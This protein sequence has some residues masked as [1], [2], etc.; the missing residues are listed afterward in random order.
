MFD[1]VTTTFESGMVIN[2]KLLSKP[3]ED[4]LNQQSCSLDYTFQAMM[5]DI[6]GD[7]INEGIIIVYMD[8]IFNFAPDNVTLTNNTRRV[9]ARLQENN[10]FLKPAKF[11]FYKTRVE[12]QGMIIEEGRI[13]MDPGKLKGIRDWPSPTMVKQTRGFLRF[14]NFY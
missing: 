9:L 11:E 12:Y 4:F 3:I 13:S 8:D 1:V 5:D 6:F 2:G 14:G 10:L 7:M